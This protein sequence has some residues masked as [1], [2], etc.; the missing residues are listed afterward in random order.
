V[1][2]KHITVLS[3]T[4]FSFDNNNKITTFREKNQTNVFRMSSIK[5]WWSTRKKAKEA[6]KAKE[7]AAKKN[8]KK[9][10]Q[11]KKEEKQKDPEEQDDLEE[12][13]NKYNEIENLKTK[14][15][16]MKIHGR[17]QDQFDID[18][19]ELDHYACAKEKFGSYWLGKYL[20]TMGEFQKFEVVNLKMDTIDDSKIF[21]I[22]EILPDESAMHAATVASE[23]GISPTLFEQLICGD[24]YFMLMSK[25]SGPSLKNTYPYNVEDIKQCLSLYYDLILFDNIDQNAL[26]VENFL[27]GINRQ[28]GNKYWKMID[29]L[30]AGEAVELDDT[31][32]AEF[33]GNT[34][35]EEQFL[36]LY[37]KIENFLFE[38]LGGT[39]LA[40]NNLKRKMIAFTTLYYGIKRFYSENFNITILS[41]KS[42][43][44]KYVLDKYFTEELKSQLFEK[45]SYFR[46]FLNNAYE[47]VL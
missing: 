24:R 38:T 4:R 12:D 26:L 9:V 2:P 41:G 13:E 20:G 47:E 8:N 31:K 44:P 27:M 22:S 7:E 34:K 28:T 19:S 14:I 17:T 5:K 32:R 46:H 11:S 18:A 15:E 1:F 43:I 36:V 3:P 30:S 37:T 29:Y 10:N 25:M 6:A 45:Y 39:W 40:D 21:L 33:T 42:V 16:V 35:E 23:K